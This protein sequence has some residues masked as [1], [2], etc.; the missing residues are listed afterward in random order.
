VVGQLSDLAEVLYA[1]LLLFHHQACDSTVTSKLEVYS[2]NSHI[3]DFVILGGTV[4]SVSVYL[5]EFGKERLAEEDVVGP[6]ELRDGKNEGSYFTLTVLQ[7]TTQRFLC[8]FILVKMPMACIAEF[9]RVEETQTVLGKKIRKSYC[10]AVH[11]YNFEQKGF[12]IHYYIIH[13]I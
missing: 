4:K 3:F 9:S 5:S 8:N 2:I 13:V 1:T 6:Q 7:A 10:T 12:I 11:S